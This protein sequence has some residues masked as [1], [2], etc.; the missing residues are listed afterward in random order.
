MLANLRVLREKLN[1]K[2][3]TLKVEPQI[4][5]YKKGF[6]FMLFGFYYLTTIMKKCIGFFITIYEK[7]GNEFWRFDEKYRNRK[8]IQTK[9]RK[10]TQQ[11]SKFEAQINRQHRKRFQF[12][13]FWILLLDHDNEKMHR[14]FHHNS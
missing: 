5:S 12:H 4:K 3:Q 2:Q 8:K 1:R 13:V 6:S 14:F 11:T 10:R 7:I 9:N